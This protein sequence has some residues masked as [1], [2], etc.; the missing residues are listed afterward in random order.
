MTKNEFPDSMRFNWGFH[1]ALD[2]VRH[3]RSCRYLPA[4]F[5][6]T[7]PLPTWDKAYCRGYNEGRKEG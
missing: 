7:R 1:D 3:G 4:T 6:Q 5:H 2:D